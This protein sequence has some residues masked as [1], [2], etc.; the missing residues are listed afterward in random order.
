[1]LILLG[2]VAFILI[3]WLLPPML[4]AA[5]SDEGVR[6][7]AI[8][9]TRTALLAGLVGIGA[10][11][12]FWIN[13]RNVRLTA[14]TLGLAEQSQKDTVKDAIERRVTE[15]YTKAAD[16]LGSEKAPVRLAGLYALERLA[17]DNPSQRQTIVNVICAY[18][19][20]PYTPP[21]AAPV[22]PSADRPSSERAPTGRGRNGP[23]RN[24]SGT[25]SACKSTRSGHRSSGSG[26]PLNGFFCGT[27]PVAQT[28]RSAG[29]P[30]ST[31][32]GRT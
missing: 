22:E 31:C 28:R 10:L 16:Q 6:V 26:R 4:Y 2:V 9:D 30:T 20:M 17:Q 32:P 7:K 21:G 11:G 19:Q 27:Y 24:G 23:S 3:W 18:L 1:M 14:E 12:T 29:R 25:R 8:T 13:S 15:L 5:T